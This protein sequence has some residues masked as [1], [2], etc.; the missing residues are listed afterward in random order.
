MPFRGSWGALPA[1]IPLKTSAGM[2][3]IRMVSSQ[4]GIMCSQRSG[5]FGLH[6]HKVHN[7]GFLTFL[8]TP[9]ALLS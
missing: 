5:I 8:L 3:S 7:E 6:T 4:I 1:D 9:A 2:T